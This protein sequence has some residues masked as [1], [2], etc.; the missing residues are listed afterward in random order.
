M[1]RLLLLSVFYIAVLQST[2]TYVVPAARDAG[3]SAGW[4]HALFFVVNGT[5]VSARLIWG[6]IAD[7][8]GGTRRA[9]TLVEIGVVAAVGG[10]IFTFALHGGAGTALPAVVLFGFGALGWNAIVYV[11]AGERAGGELANRAIATAATVI[12]LFS[13]A[14]MPPLGA[15]A[16][17]AGWDAFW[18]TIAAIAALGALVATRLPRTPSPAMAV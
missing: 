1:P 10:L 2:I 6:R 4:S 17:H 9:R 12:F 5:A 18:G 14:L 8:R 11:T 16:D 3:I 7:T 15:L 13:S